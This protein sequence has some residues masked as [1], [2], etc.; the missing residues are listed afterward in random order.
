MKIRSAT[1]RLLICACLLSASAAFGQNIF[2]AGIPGTQWGTNFGVTTNWS[3]ATSTN[4]RPASTTNC[5]FN[6]SVA[7]PVVACSQDGIN[8][9]SGGD[10]IGG[11]AGAQG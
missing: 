4:N 11:S 2:W 3:T 9:A 8:H 6:G 5:V 1:L 7:G 10:P